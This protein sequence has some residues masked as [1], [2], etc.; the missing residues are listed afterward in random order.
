[1]KFL[2]NRTAHSTSLKKQEANLALKYSQL[3]PCGHLAITDTRYYGQNS[4]P[5]L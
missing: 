1:M 5:R 3:L 2:V 4:D